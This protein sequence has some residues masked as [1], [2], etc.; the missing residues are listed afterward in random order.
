MEEDPTVYGTLNGP[1]EFYM[2]GSL[3]TWSML[4][5][6][7]KIKYPTFVIGGRFDEGARSL[8]VAIICS[9]SP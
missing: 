2:I 8:K 6:L 4:D 1:V 3:K 9:G 7:H 5:R